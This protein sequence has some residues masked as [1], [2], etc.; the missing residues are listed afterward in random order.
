MAQI[1]MEMSPAAKAHHT[2]KWA[3]TMTK[4]LITRS[5]KG[6]VKWQVVDFNGQAG[7]ESRGIV[8]LMAIRK[9]HS[10]TDSQ[11]AR[12]DLFEIVLVQV[13]GGTS[14]MPTKQDIDRMLSVRNHHK[15][16]R[17]VLIEWK[18]GTALRC[19]DLCTDGRHEVDPH[20]VFGVIP[21]RAR[22]DAAAQDISDS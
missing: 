5:T 21:S 9:N 17:A 7:A 18:K 1:K 4:W 8:D 15:A 14:A 11:F 12:G 3:R 16:D 19:F 6:G 2:A 22:L 13:K 10:P 20:M